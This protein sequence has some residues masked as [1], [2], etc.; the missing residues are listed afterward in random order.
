MHGIDHHRDVWVVMVMA[1]IRHGYV[2]GGCECTCCGVHY[3]LI[4]R[5]SFHWLP[6]FVLDLQV[7]GAAQ[8][9]A[10]NNKLLNLTRILATSVLFS[11]SELA[12]YHQSLDLWGA[13]DE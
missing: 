12:N 2:G 9:V 6:A 7:S 13:R 1:W 3:V 8:Q 10:G 5:M 11:F 4:L